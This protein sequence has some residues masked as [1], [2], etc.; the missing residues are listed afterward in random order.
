MHYTFTNQNDDSLKAKTVTDTKQLNFQTEQGILKIPF[1]TWG[2]QKLTKKAIK[3][4]A[5]EV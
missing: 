4:P 2:T 1:V 5:Y 3:F